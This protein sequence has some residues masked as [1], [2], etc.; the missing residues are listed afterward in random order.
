VKAAVVGGALAVSLS[1]DASGA[2]T[3][4]LPVASYV[5]AGSG[6][7]GLVEGYKDLDALVAALD[8]GLGGKE[9]EA[10]GGGPVGSSMP[11]GGG[12]GGI[13]APGWGGGGGG[14]DAGPYRGDYSRPRPPGADDL[15]PPGLGP[16]LP[17]LVHPH[18]G[19]PGIGPFHPAMPGG[20]GGHGGG[21]MHVGP[22]DPLFGGH[23]GFGGLG[24]P[25]GGGG[26]GGGGGGHLPP[27]LPPGARW[28]P[29]APPGLPGFTPDDFVRP[30]SGPP[31]MRP[32]HP[33]IMPPGPG[34]GN[35]GFGGGMFG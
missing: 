29:V 12:G 16:G 23:P 22:G 11:G 2:R 6:G 27:G 28:D 20:V 21:G 5:K 19:G 33:D 3:V 35:P 15:Y 10:E 4:T 32:P 34:G 24:G 1:S 18:G 7:E 13:P 31:G 26:H 25:G 14:G 8:A 9:E 17:G 30:P